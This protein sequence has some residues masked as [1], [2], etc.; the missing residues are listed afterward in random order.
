MQVAL[1]HRP[2]PRRQVRQR[3]LHDVGRDLPGQAAEVARQV[4]ERREHAARTG[5]HE[6]CGVPLQVRAERPVDVAQESRGVASAVS[7]MGKADVRAGPRS[8]PEPS[9]SRASWL[10]RASTRCRGVRCS[11]RT[12]S[13]VANVGSTTARSRTST[14]SGT[15]SAIPLETKTARAVLVGAA[16]AP[17]SSCPAVATRAPAPSTRSARRRWAAASR[18]PRSR[19]ASRPVMVAAGSVFTSGVTQG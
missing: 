3:L 7:T 10:L 9:N 16:A 15:D 13:R 2:G 17:A 1:G 12:R 6:R 4:A 8:P 11:A 19:R 5:Q 18:S 14:G